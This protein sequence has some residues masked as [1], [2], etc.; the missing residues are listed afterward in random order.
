[1][2]DAGSVPLGFLFSGLGLYAFVNGYL[3]LPVILLL[4]ITLHVDAGLTLLSRMRNKERWY[5]A[6]RRHVYQR[7]L[8][9]GWT[10][11]QVLGLYAALSG[12]LVAPAMVAATLYGQWSWVFFGGVTVLLS[13]AWYTV[14]LKL[15][16]GS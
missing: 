10:H 7:L 6:H 12:L 9:R 15:G 3:G 1:M 13:L 2:G 8:V 4:L 11:G 5:T 16:R 14:S